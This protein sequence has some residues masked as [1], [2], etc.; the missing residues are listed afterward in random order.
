M[1]GFQKEKVLVASRT[2]PELQRLEGP[3][4]GDFNP[5]VMI[6][7][8]GSKSLLN[9]PKI[10]YVAADEG[11]SLVGPDA[12]PVPGLKESINLDVSRDTQVLTFSSELIT[13]RGDKEVILNVGNF[14]DR[15]EE[16]EKRSLREQRM[17]K[18]ESLA[19]IY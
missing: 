2:L 3:S 7:L 9:V 14:L 11:S 12:E 1:V 8:L 13:R 4:A 15:L 16:F 18:G 17:E 5:D 10:R 19:K 6:C